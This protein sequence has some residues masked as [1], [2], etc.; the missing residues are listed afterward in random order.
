MNLSKGWKYSNGDG[1]ERLYLILKGSML[2]QY[3]SPG[4]PLEG[5]GAK[6]VNLR[7]FLAGGFKPVSI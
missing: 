5:G 3:G 7:N 2:Y 1:I 6:K 4:V